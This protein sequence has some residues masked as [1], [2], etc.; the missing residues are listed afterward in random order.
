MSRQGKVR[1]PRW[2]YADLKAL[3]KRFPTEG[4]VGCQALFPGRSREAILV[5]AHKLGLT[6][7]PAARSRIQIARH[8]VAVGPRA[9][10]PAALRPFD[11]V[12]TSWLARPR[13][14]SIVVPDEESVHG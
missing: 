3:R 13:P 7:K 1:G 12:I 14:G 10:D 5:K 9:I 6:V 2:T 8:T 11:A 4:A